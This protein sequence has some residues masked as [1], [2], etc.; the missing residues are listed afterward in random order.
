MKAL[1]I[2]TVSNWKT[3]SILYIITTISVY[4]SYSV[5]QKTKTFFSALSGT[6]T[7]SD[8]RK[9]L[10]IIVLFY[11]IILLISIISAMLAHRYL[12]TGMLSIRKVMLNRLFH[13]HYTYFHRNPVGKIW[14]EMVQITN[15]ACPFFHSIL[16]I[17]INIAQMIIYA[18]I[19]F[20]TNLLSGFIITAFLPLIFILT[21]FAGRSLKAIETNTLDQYRAISSFAVESLSITKMIKTT[22]SY[23][24]FLDKFFNRHQAFNNTVVK[25]AVV[26][27]YVDSIQNTIVVIAPLIIVFIVSVSPATVKLSTGD[28][29]ILYTFSPLFFNAFKSFYSRLF[30]FFGVKPS[31]KAINDLL[32]L[33]GELFGT[34]IPEENAALKI[35]NFN[36]IIGEK[37]VSLPDFEIKPGSKILIAGESGMGKSTFFNCLTGIYDDC[38]E[39][40][41]L[42][43]VSIKDYD[44]AKLRK[45]I[46][47]V[48]Q[49]NMIFTGSLKENLLM[50]LTDTISSQDLNN[51]IKALK[52]EELNNRE[53]IN[54]DKLSGGE[55]ARIN[56]AQALLRKPEVLLIDETL[57]SVDEL[58]EREIIEGIIANN[59]NMSVV[60]IT[61]RLSVQELFDEVIHLV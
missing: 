20:N 30:N 57:S 43:G 42:N 38:Q 50:G 31:L 15:I 32:E 1:K 36:Y 18:V 6:T 2:F 41:F 5:S 54:K 47:L 28:L 13:A 33:K 29:V 55:K 44:L 53:E 21:I 3:I 37:E 11:G 52:L 16:F 46:I 23:R 35:K 51:T 7:Q 60:Y 24:Y 10:I 49:E 8:G 56:L 34:K 25:G 48:S 61:H 17:P 26:R 22:S 27:S 45:K 12:Y 40:M 19:I 39:T 14:G 4:L 9:Q 58:F 59:P